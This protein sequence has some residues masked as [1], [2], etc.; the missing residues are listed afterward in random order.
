MHA[1]WTCTNLCW[2]HLKREYGQQCTFSY[3]Y[4]LP[5]LTHRLQAHVWHVT[6]TRDKEKQL[7]LVLLPITDVIIQCICMIFL[8]R[9]LHF[10]GIGGK[11][12]L[13]NSWVTA[14]WFQRVTETFSNRMK[15]A[16]AT[17]CWLCQ[18]VKQQL[19]C[20]EKSVLNIREKQDWKIVVS[21]EGTAFSAVVNAGA[22]RPM[23]LSWRVGGRKTKGQEETT[24]C[25][26]H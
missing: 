24:A 8:Y 26:S 16:D 13:H 18:K 10:T 3:F 22:Q 5:A 20:E 7:S 17:H 11:T 14:G 15:T 19:D 9:F 12:H 21:L 1:I 23:Q 2:Q 6:F 25:G 4:H